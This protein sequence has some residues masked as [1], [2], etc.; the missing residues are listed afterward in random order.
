MS[1]S[2]TNLKAFNKFNELLEKNN[3]TKSGLK[4]FSDITE[5][6]PTGNLMLNA[7]MSGSL[8]GGYANSRSTGMSGDSGTGKTFLAMNA[9]REA[10]QMDYMVFYIDT[11]GALD[12]TDFT[13]FGIDIDLLQYKRIGV[14]SELKFFI[15]NIIKT[16]TDNPGIKIMVVVDSVTMLET[17]KQVTDTE[18]GKNANDMG[19]TAKELRSLF[20]S[21]TLELSNLKIPLL[22]TSHIYDGTGM[23]ATRT[24]SG[25]KG[26]MYAA[27]VVLMLGKK[28][29]K[30]GDLKTGVICRATTN[31]NRLAKPSIIEIH[32]S[33]L[34]GMNKYVGLHYLP[35]NFSN[36]GVDRGSKLTENQWSKLK[37]HEQE[38]CTKFD[39]T[40][41]DKD[42]KDVIVT[43]YFQPK[44]K[45]H[46][47]ILR[48]TGEAIPLR[49]LFT[50]KVWTEPVLR[51]LDES[52][53]QPMF[54]YSTMKDILDDEE[55]EFDS[56]GKDEELEEV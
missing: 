4:G 27:S 33:F 51:K 49:Q 36:C 41:K 18:G 37:Q 46:N 21:F 8:F 45:A 26:P 3:K 15:H 6:I 56:L 14:I 2:D 39:V 30:E 5:F 11:E 52:V 24:M 22:F 40:E 54:K 50:A 43:Y 28:P 53:V 31:K 47:Y 20:K 48:E 29:L 10:Q 9:V 32:I 23:F 17:N 34:K 19:L 42:D 55:S 25:G 13:K 12:T 7:L 38:A 16:A 44:S 1:K 35:F